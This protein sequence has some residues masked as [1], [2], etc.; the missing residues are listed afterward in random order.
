VLNSYIQM[1]NLAYWGP[2]GGPAAPKMNNKKGDIETNDEDLNLSNAQASSG[3][4]IV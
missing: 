3:S 2:T 4:Q 1:C